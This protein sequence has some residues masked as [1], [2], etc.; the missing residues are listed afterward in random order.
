MGARR[1]NLAL[2]A[3]R[4]LHSRAATYSTIY[5]QCKVNFN[6]YYYGPLESP[7]HSIRRAAK[8]MA[9]TVAVAAMLSAS[10]LVARRS[11]DRSVSIWKM[12]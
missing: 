5:A 4:L 7:L 1:R 2:C 8:R 10:C 6:D 12:K 9:S 3:S 11:Q